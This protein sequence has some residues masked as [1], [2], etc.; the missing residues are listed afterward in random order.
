MSYKEALEGM[1]WQFAYRSV[2]KDNKSILWTG[3]LS[4]LEGAFEALGWDNPKIIPDTDGVICDVEGCSE[5]VEAQGGMWADT[6]YW[7][8]CAKHSGSCRK[9][10][11][12]PQ[13]K[14]RALAREASRGEDGCLSTGLRGRK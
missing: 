4:A 7:C 10:N 13:M 5:W 6:G 12:Q 8:L 2:G 9:G 11:P 3:G 14:Q 1:V